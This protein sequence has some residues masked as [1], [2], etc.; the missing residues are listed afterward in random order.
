MGRLEA[1]CFSSGSDNTLYALVF[2]YDLSITKGADNAIVALIKSNSSPSGPNAL[3]WQ[4]V[5]T[6]HQA[7]LSSFQQASGL[8]RYCPIQC[9]VDPNGGFLAWSYQTY[10]PGQTRSETRPGGFRYDPFSTTPSA[11]T[12]GKRSFSVATIPQ[13]GPLPTTAPLVQSANYTIVGSCADLGVLGNSIYTYC[14]DRTSG[15]ISMSELLSPEIYTNTISEIFGDP[16]STIYMLVQSGYMEYG[17][18]TSGSTLKALILTGA[19]AGSVLNVP[20]NIT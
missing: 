8:G 4:V 1:A 10:L 16:K 11:A 19:S 3:T 2:G 20:N 13:S 12:T 18:L 5:S 15:P 6:V 14:A 7:K 17:R 9:L